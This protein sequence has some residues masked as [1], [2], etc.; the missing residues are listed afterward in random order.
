MV[1][2]SKTYKPSYLFELDD[3]TF[4]ALDKEILQKD[5]GIWT[6]N[7]GLY[8]DSHKDYTIYTDKKTLKRMAEFILKYLEQN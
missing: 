3:E 5:G 2:R 6:M 8:E 4:M 7:F 1:K